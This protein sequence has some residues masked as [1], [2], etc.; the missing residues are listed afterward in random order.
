[1]SSQYSP[2]EVS[3]SRVKF[4]DSVSQLWQT[5][6]HSERATSRNNCLSYDEGISRTTSYVIESMMVL[7]LGKTRLMVYRIDRIDQKPETSLLRGSTSSH[8][9]S[10]PEDPEADR[11]GSLKH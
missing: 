4:K 9:C 7:V 6:C 1:M 11:R 5:C 10:C 3:R 2:K 8:M